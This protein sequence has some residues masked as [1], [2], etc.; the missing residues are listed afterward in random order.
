MSK[1]SVSFH[2]A[3]FSVVCVAQGGFPH[4]EDSFTNEL[5]QAFTDTWPLAPTWPSDLAFMLLMTSEKVRSERRHFHLCSLVGL[6]TRSP[7]RL[8]VSTSPDTT[9]LR[10][11]A[12][13]WPT[14]SSV[15]QGL[16]GLKPPNLPI[17][18]FVHEVTYPTKKRLGGFPQNL[19][20]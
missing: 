1:R 6:V 8:L 16:K 2:A 10:A 20:E 12:D 11:F 19:C 14:G 17:W 3:H 9:G 5:L 13:I 4:G 18:N 15:A 7:F